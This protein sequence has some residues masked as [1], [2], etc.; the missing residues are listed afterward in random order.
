[1]S[2]A[3]KRA[4]LANHEARLNALEARLGDSK[5]AVA[6]TSFPRDTGE[7]AAE[8][9]R[10]AW[11]RNAE[12]EAKKGRALYKEREELRERIGKALTLTGRWQKEFRDFDLPCRM[13]RDIERALK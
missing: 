12:A 3:S 9:A 7:Q 4:V 1:M 5:A 2:K 10:L 6:E 13:C 8:I 11:K